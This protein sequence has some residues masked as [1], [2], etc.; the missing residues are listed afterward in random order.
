MQSGAEEA[1]RIANQINAKPRGISVVAAIRTGAVLWASHGIGTCA[2]GTDP[3]TSVVDTNLMVHGVDNLMVCD[4][5][6][7]PSQVQSPHLPISAIAYKIADNYIKP[8]RWA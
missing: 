5:S 7:L 3:A 8:V 4:G 1:V 2:M 6:V